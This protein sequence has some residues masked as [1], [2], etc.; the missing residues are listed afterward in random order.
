M[1]E[2]SVVAA[3]AVSVVAAAWVVAVVSA[4]VVRFSDPLG[5]QSLRASHIVI[6]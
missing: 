3:V 4:V 2:V 5:C 1:V 6:L